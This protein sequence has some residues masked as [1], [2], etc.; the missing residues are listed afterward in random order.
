MPELRRLKELEQ[1]NAKLKRTCADLALIPDG[2][3]GAARQIEGTPVRLSPT[4]TPGGAEYVRVGYILTGLAGQKVPVSVTV[5]RR[6]EDKPEETMVSVA[7]TDRPTTDRN[8]REQRVG[9]AALSS[10]AY[11]LV[12]RVTLPNGSIAERRQR[13]VV[14]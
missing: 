9:L 13:I 11:D 2:G 7:F 14:R 10:G 3:Q 8:F 5:I 4:F 6:E 12:V 1:E